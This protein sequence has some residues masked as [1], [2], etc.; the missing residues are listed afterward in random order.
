MPKATVILYNAV[1]ADGMGDF[2]HF[3]DIYRSLSENPKISL[4]Y[5]FVSIIYS[6]QEFIA[7]RSALML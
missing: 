2:Q 7:H 4:N 3:V 6:S 5:R 1:L